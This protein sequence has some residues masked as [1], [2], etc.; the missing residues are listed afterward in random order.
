MLKIGNDRS[1]DVLAALEGGVG[2]EELCRLAAHEMP[3]VAVEAERR[4]YLDAHAEVV[5]ADGHR[6]VVGNGYLS[7]N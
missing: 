7:L 5:D 6:M 2:L 4:A 1:V 3:A